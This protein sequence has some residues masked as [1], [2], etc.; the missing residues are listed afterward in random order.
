MRVRGSQP[1][2]AKPIAVDVP[3]TNFDIRFEGIQ[4]GVTWRP[5]ELDLSRGRVVSMWLSGLPANADKGNLRVFAGEERASVLFIEDKTGKR[6]V[7]VQLT[8]HVPVGVVKLRLELGDARLDCGEL[9]V[10]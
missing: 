4:D 6:Q 5:N 1:S 7:N 10:F 8:E 3:L 9:R 2:N